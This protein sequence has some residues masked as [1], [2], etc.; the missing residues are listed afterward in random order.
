MWKY[1][2][3]PRSTFYS[4]V[5]RF[6]YW[7]R[8]GLLVVSWNGFNARWGIARIN[9]L[10]LS[11]FQETG[12][13]Y[14]GGV[15]IVKDNDFKLAAISIIMA[16]FLAYAIF[17]F[18]ICWKTS[19]HVVDSSWAD[20]IDSCVKHMTVLTWLFISRRGKNSLTPTGKYEIFPLSRWWVHWF[21]KNAM[22]LPLSWTNALYLCMDWASIY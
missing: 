22:L 4:P 20:K 18:S 7:N 11:W 3:T 12:T 13:Y 19:S 14:E 2:G 6:P 16:Y 21:L 10:S 9:V 1:Y 8:S 15:V 17:A 5:I